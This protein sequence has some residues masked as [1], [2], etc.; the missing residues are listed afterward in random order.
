[1]QSRARNWRGAQAKDKDVVGMWTF[2][3]WII[4]MLN[5]SYPE[6]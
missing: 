6:M 2:T 3:A 4:V 5:M 1:M